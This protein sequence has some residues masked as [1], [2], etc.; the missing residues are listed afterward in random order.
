M[1]ETTFPHSKDY[2][3]SPISWES[4]KTELQQIVTAAVKTNQQAELQ[5]KL[6][7]PEETCKLF[8][9]KISKTTLSKWTKDGHLQEHRLGGRVFYK[10]GEVVQ[11]V[12]TLKKY[13]RAS[14]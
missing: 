13:R 2:F 8:Q 14:L 5:D 4:I 1:T 12:Q 7:S 11:S 9:P 3:L 6:L 10:Y